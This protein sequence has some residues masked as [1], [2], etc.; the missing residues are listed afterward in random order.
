MIRSARVQFRILCVILVVTAI[1]LSLY[2]ETTTS[3]HLS[4]V[5]GGQYGYAA[6]FQ[7]ALGD[8]DGDGDLDA[9]FAN[10]HSRSE[11]WMNDGAGV[12]RNAYRNI[13]SEA[14]GVGIGDLDGDGDLDLLMTP[15]SN[16]ESSRIYLNDGVGG[17]TVAAHDLG[18]TTITANCVSLFDVEGDGDL[19]AGIYY[20][21]N[22]RQSR[23]YLNDGTGHF[24]STDLRLP[25]LA[26]WGDIDEDGDIDAVCLQH[27]QNGSGYKVFLNNGNIEFEESQHIAALTFFSPGS[28]DLGDIDGDGDLDFV[29]IGGASLDSPL[30]VL[31]NDGTGS[32]THMTGSSFS[33]HAGR[34][35]LGDFNGDG[36]ADVYIGCMDHPKLIGLSDRAGF[37]TDS[38]LQLG[39]NDMA[40]IG[41]IGDLDGD[42][43][44]D[45][46]VAIYGQGGPNE[47]WLNTTE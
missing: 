1:S 38:G 21:E 26:I 41:A 24:T 33:A 9:V 47:V 14:H 3:E 25:G 18:D 11:V 46:F 20:F 4:L 30:A 35:A 32:F 40:G 16:S 19:D 42:G 34:L 13:G 5:K 23:L 31:M 7:V 2:A 6:T 43:D 12:F 37:F 15:A 28:G 17:F 29:A 27:A 22:Q 8:L 45:L 36:A 44:L 10:M 39:L